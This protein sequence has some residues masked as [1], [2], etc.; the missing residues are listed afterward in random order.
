MIS[1]PQSPVR[2]LLIGM[3]GRDMCHTDKLPFDSLHCDH[4]GIMKIKFINLARMHTR[5]KEI[6][7]KT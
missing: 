2:H 1:Y 3:P 6:Y 7:T 5:A 4:L